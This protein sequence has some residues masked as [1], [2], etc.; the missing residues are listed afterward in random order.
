ML[1]MSDIIFLPT[2]PHIFYQHEFN[3]QEVA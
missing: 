2:A 3:L 1:N